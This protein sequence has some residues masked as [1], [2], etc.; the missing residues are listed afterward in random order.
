MFEPA[1]LSC[2][3]YLDP[4]KHINGH[5]RN[6]D[7]QFCEGGWMDPIFD[8][9]RALV[10]NRWLWGA[11]TLAA[12]FADTWLLGCATMRLFGRGHEEWSVAGLW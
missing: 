9:M 11:F 4:K 8:A 3:V 5:H 2:T 12:S 6:L 7:E 10:S 1:L